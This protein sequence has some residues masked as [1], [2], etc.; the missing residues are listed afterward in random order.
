MLAETIFHHTGCHWLL[1]GRGSGCRLR[2]IWWICGICRRVILCSVIDGSSRRRNLLIVG[3]FAGRAQPAPSW[4]RR[5]AFL[6]ANK[7]KP[8]PVLSTFRANQHGAGSAAISGRLHLLVLLLC[9]IC[10]GLLTF[11]ASSRAHQGGR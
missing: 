8:L 2:N 10:S 5:D 4:R 3:A 9:V 11:A 6:A 7:G 1:L